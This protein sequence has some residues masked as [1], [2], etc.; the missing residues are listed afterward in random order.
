MFRGLCSALRAFGKNQQF[1]AGS[2]NK[3]TGG[4]A[5][6]RPEALNRQQQ[7]LDLL[8][9]VVAAADDDQVLGTPN[10]V[11]VIVINEP[12]VPGVKPSI[13]DEVSRQSLVIVVTLGDR[14]SSHADPA[15]ETT[16]DRPAFLIM[17]FD[18]QAGER[19]SNGRQYP[20]VAWAS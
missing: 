12:D 1:F 16:L 7:R 9:C 19:F 20:P 11:E 17:N 14:R 6:T 8:R 2:F 18:R 3:D 5:A 13:F 10:D 4:N 15:G